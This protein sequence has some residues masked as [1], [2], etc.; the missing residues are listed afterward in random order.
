MANL[1]QTI[2]ILSFSKSFLTH[3]ACPAAT[4]RT[5]TFCSRQVTNG[6]IRYNG[7]FG[8]FRIYRKLGNDACAGAEALRA[9]WKDK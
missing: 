6:I 3:V 2:S 9:G 1:R 7:S 4:F 8:I 5:S